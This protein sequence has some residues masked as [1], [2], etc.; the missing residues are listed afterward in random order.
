MH[1]FPESDIARGE[2]A[3]VSLFP[4]NAM[5]PCCRRSGISKNLFYPMY[6]RR[7]KRKDRQQDEGSQ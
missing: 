4:Q 1:L 5:D 2:R 6:E 3:V 7:E